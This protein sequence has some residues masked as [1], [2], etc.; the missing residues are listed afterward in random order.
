MTTVKD[1][2]LSIENNNFSLIDLVTILELTVHELDINTISEMARL[3]NK[4]PNGIRTSNRYRK[5][6]I[7]KQTM[8]IK[9]LNN[10]NLPF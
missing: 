6:N 7:G 10:N 2:V 5:T 8:C 1:I 4:S 3:E 9:G